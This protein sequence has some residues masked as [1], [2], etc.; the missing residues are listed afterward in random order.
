MISPFGNQLRLPSSLLQ[1][2]SSS[3]TQTAGYPFLS[4]SCYPNDFQHLVV[5][6]NL[7]NVHSILKTQ[8]KW[9]AFL[10]HQLWPLFLMFQ[11][12]S[13]HTTCQLRVSLL[14]TPFLGIPIQSDNEFLKKYLLLFIMYSQRL[15]WHLGH[16]CLVMF[17][18]K[19]SWGVQSR[20][21][22]VSFYFNSG[23]SIFLF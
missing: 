18:E 12:F 15:I 14:V 22:L 7:V 2:V 11:C 10:F 17:N 5:L 20:E 23:W 9:E 4:M 8:L 21:N 19:K 3:A 13:H 16:C 6:V 1:T